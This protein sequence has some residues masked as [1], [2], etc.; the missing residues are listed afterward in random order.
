MK[1]DRVV[2]EELTKYLQEKEKETG[3]CS[4]EEDDVIQLELEAEAALLSMYSDLE[5]N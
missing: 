5:W 3:C 4:L 2:P 1:E